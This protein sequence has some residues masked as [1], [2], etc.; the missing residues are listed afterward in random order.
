MITARDRKIMF[1]LLPLVVIV[2]YW[3]MVLA[4]KRAQSDKVS[5]ELTKAQSARDTAEQQ[6]ASLNTAKASFA[7][8][9]ATVIRLGK[10]VPTTVDMPSLLVQLDRAARGTGITI[11]DLKPGVATDAGSS[12]AGAG[13]SS[14]APTTSAPGGGNNPAAPGAPPAQS[15]PGKQAQKAGTGVTA[16]NNTNQAQANKSNATPGVTPSAGAGTTPSPPGLQSVPLTFTLDGTFFSLADFFHRMKRFVR[17]VNDQIVVRGRLLT[18]ESFDFKNSDGAAGAGS[19]TLQADVTATIYLS[20][21]SQGAAAG[22]SSSG[23]ASATGA[24]PSQPSGTG[25]STTPSTPTATATP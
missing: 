13:A 10:A 23:P 22:A 15:F 2:G 18:I 17:V 25:T 1:I 11:N 4:P 7:S 8:D 21:P 14:T 9:Y 16:A 5:A 3:F 12:S 19:K 6:V 20:P 24:N